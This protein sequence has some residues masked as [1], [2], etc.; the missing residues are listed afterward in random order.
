MEM[1]RKKEKK[2]ERRE[3]AREKDRERE[4]E[5]ERKKDTHL[6]NGDAEPG[7]GALGVGV[8]GERE[9]G[10]CHADGQ[11][12]ESLCFVPRNV[13]RSLLRNVNPVASVDLLGSEEH[14]RVSCEWFTCLETVKMSYAS[15]V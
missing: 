12:V 9:V 7:G 4:R 2:R 6:T 10:L 1:E 8:C 13:R 14:A 3:R 15:P 5:R 11:V